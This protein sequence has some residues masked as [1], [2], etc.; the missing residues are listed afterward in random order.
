MSNR[1]MMSQSERLAMLQRQLGSQLAKDPIFQRVSSNP[2]ELEI[3]EWEKYKK[4]VKEEYKI[5]LDDDPIIN[6]RIEYLQNKGK[7][8]FAWGNIEGQS[9][10]MDLLTLLTAATS[11]HRETND[12]ERDDP[13]VPEI[14]SSHAEE[15]YDDLQMDLKRQKDDHERALLIE[16]AELKRRLDEMEMRSQEI[17]DDNKRS[18]LK[19]KKRK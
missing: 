10:G 7:I 11:R 3:L 13:P 4:R 18:L 8:I 12:R 15:R 17:P 9:S 19:R 14:E 2:L 5:N 6:N 16:N 1:G